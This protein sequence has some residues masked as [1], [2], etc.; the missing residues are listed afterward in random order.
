VNPVFK[1]AAASAEYGWV[2]GVMTV[3]F[4]AVFLGWAF[5]AYHPANR[6]AMNEAAAMPLSDGGDQ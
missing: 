5:W 1:A 6:A 4:L 2:M 3:V